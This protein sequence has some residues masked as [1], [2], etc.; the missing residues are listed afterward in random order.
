VLK[1][2]NARNNHVNSAVKMCWR[3]KDG[4]VS[5]SNSDGC[6]DGSTL[7]IITD[8]LTVDLSGHEPN[9]SAKLRNSDPMDRNPRNLRAYSISTFR[10]KLDMNLA[11][12]TT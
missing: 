1:H 2:I 9:E 5:F 3:L 10:A 12:I 7:F 11:V 6:D 8:P 4:R